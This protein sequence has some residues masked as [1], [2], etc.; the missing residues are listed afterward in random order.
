MQLHISHTNGNVIDVLIEIIEFTSKVT[1]NWWKTWSACRE[2]NC[3]YCNEMNK[4]H[5][6]VGF[7]TYE[8]TGY[9]E[10]LIHLY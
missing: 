10:R 1:S 2:K 6:I 7:V 4:R 3:I 8:N 5:G 9:F